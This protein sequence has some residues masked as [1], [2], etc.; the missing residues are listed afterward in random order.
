MEKVVAIEEY[1]PSIDASGKYFDY[2]GSW[3]HSIKCLCGGRGECVYETKAKFSAHCRTKCHQEWLSVLT[4]SNKNY[5]KEVIEL[6]KLT[7]EQTQLITKLSSVLTKYLD[8]F[9]IYT[10]AK[11]KNAIVITKDFD[12]VQLQERF[13]SPPKI[14]F[15]TCGNTSN[16]KMKEILKSKFQLISELLHSNN[17]VELSD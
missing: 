2:V 12:F 17:L 7:E 3:T 16:Q 9:S 4:K 5:Y 8:D 10:Y 1:V 13:G 15:V 11:E 6:R 14:I